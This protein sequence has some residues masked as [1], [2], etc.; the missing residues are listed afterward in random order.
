[1]SESGAGTA[2]EIAGIVWDIIDADDEHYIAIWIKNATDFTWQMGPA[3]SHHGKIRNWGN[4]KLE[5]GESTYFYMN[6]EGM[7][8]DLEVTLRYKKLDDSNDYN[9]VL[10]LYASVPNV[11]DNQ[12]DIRV[13]DAYKD[14]YMAVLSGPFTAE[15]RGAWAMKCRIAVSVKAVDVFMLMA[16][17][18]NDSGAQTPQ[19]HYPP[20]QSGGAHTSKLHHP[21]RRIKQYLRPNGR[22]VHICTTPEEIEKLKHQLAIQE[23]HEDFDLYLHGSPE[24]LD[25]IREIHAHHEG[26]RKDL[27]QNHSDLY[28]TFEHI[29]NE[30]NALNAELHTLSEHNIAFDANFSRYGYSARIRT[31]EPD[32]PDSS[33]SSTRSTSHEK[34]NWDAERQQGR[35]MTFYKRPVVRQ[36][37]HKGLLWRAAEIEEVASFELFV[38]LLYVGIIAINGDRAAENATGESLLQFSV[39]FILSWKLWTDLTL[40]IS[41][42]E[43]GMIF[44]A[45]EMIMF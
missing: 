1:M 11:G 38:D 9:E 31:R 6:R 10:H 25:T 22:K 37:Y 24:H 12:Y 43:T 14:K 20:D 23:G 13:G 7:G 4:W 3:E 17:S 39:T 33:A 29:H 32:G 5:P 8:V 15:S 42:F 35:T 19:V 45:R 28:D 44:R 36:Y 41:W 26:R 34:R 21:V 30:L 27:R 2:G 16:S 18:P 40:V